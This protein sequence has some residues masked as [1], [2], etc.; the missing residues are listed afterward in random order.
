MAALTLSWALSN[1]ECQDA[2][3]YAGCL[4]LAM[5]GSMLKVRLPGI[6]GTFSLGFVFILIGIVELSL[7]EVLLL[8]SAAATVQCLWRTKRKPALIQILFSVA[9]LII[10]VTASYGVFHLGQQFGFSDHVIGWLALA[11]AV[12]Y[13]LNTGFLAV[14]LALVENKPL[15]KMWEHWVLWS[16]P[17][18]LAGAVLA[19]AFIVSARQ[20]LD[21]KSAVL[22]TPIL[23]LIYICYRTYIERR[24]NDSSCHI[25]Q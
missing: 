8:S 18:F 21:P 24:V 25:A 3:R 17:Y 12:Q 20:S 15:N 16:F 9:N 14:V 4:I 2:L 23:Y 11:A 5:M 10:A 1:W 22:L 7:G 13:L 19:G 6:A